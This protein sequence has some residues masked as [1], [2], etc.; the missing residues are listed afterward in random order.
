MLTPSMCSYSPASS[1]PV[2][3]K[4]EQVLGTRQRIRLGAQVS[5]IWHVIKTRT[6]LH[7]VD[8][9]GQLLHGAGQ[10]LYG[11]HL[12]TASG[13][14]AGSTS[15]VGKYKNPLIFHPYNQL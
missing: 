10:L 6:L 11:V 14:V 8:E 15:S 5:D 4:A 12:L 9:D 2:L 7:R 1:F 3:Q 13:G